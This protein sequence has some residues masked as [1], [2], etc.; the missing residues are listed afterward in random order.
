MLGVFENKVETKLD[1]EGSIA[2]FF[3]EEETKR[4]NFD[5]KANNNDCLT[6]LETQHEDIDVI[7]GFLSCISCF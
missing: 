6:L 2:T 3:L 7:L 1:L 4:Q 5:I